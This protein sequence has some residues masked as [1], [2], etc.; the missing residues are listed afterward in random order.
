MQFIRTQLP[1]IYII[2]FTVFASGASFLL[3]DSEVNALKEIGQTLGKKDWDFS[4]HP[5]SK[6]AGWENITSDRL[7]SN[8]TCSCSSTV[9]HVVSIVLRGQDLS[10]ML[11][12]E[13]VKL[14]F[15]Q[16]IDLNYNYLN[17]SIPKEW[18]SMKL[19]NISLAG[20]RVSGGLPIELAN[21]PTLAKLTLD[22]NYLSG[23]LPPEL[24]DLANLEMW[25][26]SSN[27]FT[28]PFPET[29][30]KLTTLTDFRINDNHFTGKI[31]EFIQNW[32]NLTRIGM[33]ASGLRGPIPLGISRLTKMFDMRISDLTG[34]DS[35]F[36]SLSNMTN[37]TI[38]VLRSCNIIGGVPS[39]LFSLNQMKIIDLSFNKLIGQLPGSIGNMQTA[40]FLFLT[41]NLLKGPVPAFTYLDKNVNITGIVPCLKSFQCYPN[42]TSSFHINCGGRNVTANGGTQYMDNTEFTSSTRFIQKTGNNWGF[43]TTGDFLDNGNNNDM[44]IATTNSSLT[45]KDPELYTSARISPI[46]LTYY[47]FCLKNGT[48]TVGLH[49]AEII[50]ANDNNYRSLGR[51]IFD[52]YIQGKIVRKDFNIKDEAGGADKAII[53]R[54]AAVVNDGTLDIRFQWAGR[55]TTNIPYAGTYGPLVSAISVVPDTNTISVGIIVGLV[56]AVLGLVAV[57]LVLLWWRGWF[58]QKDEIDEDMRGLDLQTGSFTL[59]QIKAATNNFHAENKIGEGGFGPVY[60]GKLLDGTVIAVKQLSSKSKQGNRE[61]VTEIGMISALQHPNLVKLYGCSMEGNQLLVVYEYMENNSLASILF[62]PEQCQSKL[63][64]RTRYRI[65]LDIARALAYLHEGSRLK[66][67]H[68]DVKATNILLDKDLNAKV[69]DFG[70]AKLNDED[71]SHISTRIA[72]TR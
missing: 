25:T 68:R 56:I 20:N 35:A 3:P 60:K 57:T 39:F 12:P 28:G 5:C 50:I 65:C 14:S 10:G 15:L 46:S 55:G 31:P 58:G 67:I 66:I 27:N 34:L 7:Q 9:C 36:P 72:G 30:A 19:V 1:L 64:W 26:M 43:S 8:V 38:L 6:K 42:P 40:N 51:R 29:F 37:L 18:G 71:A 53:R 47:G 17:G 49:F 48:Y 70:L 63:D 11:P 2:V 24:G 23:L 13:L 32:T 33:Q 4:V 16:Q 61:F 44:Y 22:F 21:I 62:D 54:F 52:I 69:S 41:G 59:R 45:M